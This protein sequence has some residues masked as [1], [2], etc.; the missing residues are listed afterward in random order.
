VASNLNLDFKVAGPAPA[1]LSFDIDTKV[2][3]ALTKRFAVGFETYNG[4]GTT[5]QFGAFGKADQAAYAAIDTGVGKWDFNFGLGH[6]YGGNSDGWVLKAI[7]SVPI[8][9]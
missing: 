1:P 7:V 6:G 8:D 5:K 3:Y 4:L 2:S 9:N